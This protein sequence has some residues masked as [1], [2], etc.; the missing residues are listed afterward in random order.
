MDTFKESWAETGVT[1]MCDGW[2]STNNRTMVNFLLYNCRGTVYHK[3][4]DT[5]QFSNDRELI[6]GLML[7]DCQFAELENVVQIVIDNG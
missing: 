3:S 2:T 5:T 7:K 4:F 6:C 1:I